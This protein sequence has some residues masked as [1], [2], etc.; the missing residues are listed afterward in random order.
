[1][2][3]QQRRSA[4]HFARPFIFSLR[5]DPVS[6]S[7]EEIAKI[8]MERPKTGNDKCEGAGCSC[9]KQKA[10]NRI[11][12]SR[13]FN[14]SGGL[15]GRAADRLPSATCRRISPACLRSVPIFRSSWTSCCCGMPADGLLAL[16]TARETGM[17]IVSP[18][19]SSVVFS[20]ILRPIISNPASEASNGP[21]GRR[22][23]RLDAYGRMFNRL[24]A[25]YNV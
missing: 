17:P 11:E 3:R 6:Y 23:T 15:V 24:L 2:A 9:S 25:A 13:S 19:V 22:R 1:M 8:S 10:R 5:L 14:L 18:F 16:K 7:L 12:F 4:N 20:A 21:T